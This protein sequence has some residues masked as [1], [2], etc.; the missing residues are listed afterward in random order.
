MPRTALHRPP[1]RP[2]PGSHP[3]QHLRLQICPAATR[4]RRHFSRRAQ[5]PRRCA[6]GHLKHRP[7]QLLGLTPGDAPY[8]HW[9]SRPQPPLAGAGF[10]IKGT[11]IQGR[12]APGSPTSPGAPSTT[13]RSTCS[14]GEAPARP[15]RSRHPR[16]RLPTRIAHRHLELTDAK[17]HPGAPPSAHPSPAGPQHPPA[18]LHPRERQRA[19]HRVDDPSGRVVGARCRSQRPDPRDPPGRPPPP[20]G[21][22]RR[23]A[24]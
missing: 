21:H 2:G 6:G 3:G 22:P 11:H 5:H 23:A 16:R 19:P 13:A 20:L 24:A 1:A 4:P 18:E 15:H 14:A 7:V 12:P 8:A 9:T 17:G 10:D